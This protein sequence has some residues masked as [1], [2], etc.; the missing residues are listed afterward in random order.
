MILLLSFLGHFF[1]S[2]QIRNLS[3]VKAISD[4][5]Q[6]EL[7][8]SSYTCRM[9]SQLSNLGMTVG[10]SA[11]LKVDNEPTKAQSFLFIFILL[12]C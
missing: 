6:L 9:Y 5:K 10:Q 2:I 3:T 12:N 1:Q 8:V 11:F 7:Y 4:I